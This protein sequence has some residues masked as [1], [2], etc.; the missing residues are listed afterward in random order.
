MKRFDCAEVHHQHQTQK[1]RQAGEEEAEVI[2]GGGQNGVDGIA[3]G[4]GEMIAVHAM[5]ILDM[6]DK[7]F[8]GGAALRVRMRSVICAIAFGSAHVLLVL[9]GVPTG[10]VFRFMIS[11]VAFG[12]MFPYLI[13]RVQ[14]GLAYAY[15]LHWSYYAP[16]TVL[17]HFF[18]LSV[19]IRR[20]HGVLIPHALNEQTE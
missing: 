2:S 6:A 8:D 1:R 7:R 4:M 11:A 3:L 5:L 12:F 20:K 18:D 15:V 16:S 9:G 17:P 13:L 10:Y 19:M 14:N